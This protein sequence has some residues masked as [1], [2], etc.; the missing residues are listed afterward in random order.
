MKLSNK[1]K[2]IEVPKTGRT[3]IQ[4][5]S[6]EMY[7][8]PLYYFIPSIT[9]DQRF[10][11]YHQE[12]P[13]TINDIQLY[14]L[15]LQNGESV[16][17]TNGTCPDAKW[18][19]WGV[20]PARG[21]LG[22]RSALDTRKGRVIYFDGRKVRCVNLY[23]LEDKLLFTIPDDRYPISQNCVTGNGEWFVYILVDKEKYNNLLAAR[24]EKG[25]S[26]FREMAYTCK[27]TQVCGYNLNTGEQ[28]VIFRINYPVHHI[29]GYDDINLVFSHIPGEKYGIGFSDIE[30]D[31]YTILRPQDE[32]GGKI[33]HHVP[34]ERGIAYEVKF[35]EDAS[36]VG[37]INPYTHKKYEWTVPDGASHTGCDPAGKLFFY[38]VN[39]ARIKAL[40]KHDP[41]GE[42]K[43]ELITGSWK[44]YGKGQK[45]HFHPRLT[46]D[47]NWMQI[48]AGDPQT[49]TNHIFLVDVSDLNE[50]LGIPQ[51]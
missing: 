8:Y 11:V 15:D 28:K 9:E 25:G 2:K 4:L 20:D 38:H 14:R 33:I 32:K 47:R 48:V 24:L 41:Q 17:I 18:K 12:V 6:G 16:Q 1:F 42:D 34:T 45:A 29:H 37:I 27:A 40:K 10:L 51:V 22:D 7:C 46:P 49:E 36:W 3:A 26:Y 31:W 30:G 35:R 43:W 13:G 21:V 5:T 44:T 50:T 19:P 39:G 23:T